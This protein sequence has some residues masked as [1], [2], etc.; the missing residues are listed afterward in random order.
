M[1]ST[2]R[3]DICG[4]LTARTTKAICLEIAG[5]P[6][7]LPLSEIEDVTEALDAHVDD[8]VTVRIPLWLA[9]EKEIE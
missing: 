3:V 4:T 2:E 9:E 8:E 1:R 7:W 5:E 6:V